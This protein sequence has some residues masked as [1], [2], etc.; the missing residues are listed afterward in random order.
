MVYIFY[1]LNILLQPHSHRKT[2]AKSEDK[3]WHL[4]VSGERRVSTCNDD[5]SKN[6][7]TQR[8]ARM[9]NYKMLSNTQTQYGCSNSISF[10]S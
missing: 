3:D 2:T 9:T 6:T 5:G 10:M 8:L 1:T 7:E 4:A